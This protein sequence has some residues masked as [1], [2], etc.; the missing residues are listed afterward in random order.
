MEMVQRQGRRFK[1][2]RVILGL[3]L[4]GG[5]LALV[6]VLLAWLA[7]RRLE[8]LADPYLTDDPAKLPDVDVGAGAR[9]RADR[10]GGRAQSLFRI[11]ARCRRRAVAR[12]QGEVPAGERRQHAGRTTTSRRA[13]RAGL[14]ARGVPASAIYRD[15]AGV[16]TRDSMLRAKSVFGQQRLIVVSQGFHAARAIF[17]ARREGIEAWGL[18]ARDV[19]AGLQHLHRAAALSVGAARLSTTSGSIRRRATPG[20]RSPSAWIRPIDAAAACPGDRCGDRRR[21][22]WRRSSRWPRWRARRDRCV[23]P[24]LCRR[25]AG[26]ACPQVDTVLVLGTAPFGVGG[27]DQRT[28]SYRLDTAAGL[29]HGGIV[30]H[31]LVSGIRIGDGLRRGV[32]HARRAGG[33]RRAGHGDRARSARQPHLGF[34]RAGALRLRQATP[35]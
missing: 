23:G 24:R 7:E 3:V 35:R 1:G 25:R 19:D 14:I 4:A 6:L 15:F 26:A 13:M 32:G 12:R 29:W 10:A 22:R 27:Q 20:R 34:G 28:L 8:R 16:R 11:S 5:A 18:A 2:M 21:C 9:R 33:A 30:E 31:F 17:L